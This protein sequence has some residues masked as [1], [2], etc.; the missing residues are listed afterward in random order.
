MPIFEYVCERC[1]TKHEEIVLG[2]EKEITCPVCTT[3]M[4]K[5][6]S[7]CSFKIIW[8]GVDSKYF[9]DSDGNWLP[10]RSPKDGF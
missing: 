1:K 10:D 7:V 4:E 3:K 5:V 9:Y 6:P 8:K 2:K